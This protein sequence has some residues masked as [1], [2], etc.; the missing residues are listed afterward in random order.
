MELTRE[1]LNTSLR[2]LIAR[3]QEQAGSS[4]AQVSYRDNYDTFRLVIQDSNV[5]VSVRGFVNNSPAY[6]LNGRR[7][8]RSSAVGAVMLAAAGAPAG[9]TVDG[10][11]TA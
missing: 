10:F 3:S 1:Q 4:I 9:S 2:T 8:D 5:G 6:Q 11:F 7:W